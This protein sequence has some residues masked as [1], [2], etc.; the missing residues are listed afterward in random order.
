MNSRL[1]FT[2]INVRMTCQSHTIVYLSYLV[3]FLLNMEE[4]CQIVFVLFLQ[5]PELLGDFSVI[6][7]QK[8]SRCRFWVNI[9]K[10]VISN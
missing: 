1:Y 4:F 8:F 2:V 7:P 5:M 3:I 6:F 9:R 10:S